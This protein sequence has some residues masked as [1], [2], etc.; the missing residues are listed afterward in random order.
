[1]NIAIKESFQADLSSLQ[2]ND[3]NS[4]ELENEHTMHVPMI[5]TVEKVQRYKTCCNCNK[6]II[7]LE[8]IVVKCDYCSHMMRACNCSTKLYVN[9]NVEIDDKEKTL[10]IFDDVLKATLGHFDGE[11]VETENIVEQL[12]LQENISILHNDRN[13]ITKMEKL[14]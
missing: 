10:T 13:V 4:T 8:S 6:R 12:L 1:M 14:S 11:S 2:F 9:V 7:Q 3:T 5:S